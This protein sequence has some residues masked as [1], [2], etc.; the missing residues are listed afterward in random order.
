MHDFK[1][2]DKVVMPV[3]HPESEH[4]SS[5]IEEI[6]GLPCEVDKVERDNYRGTLTVLVKPISLG[7]HYVWVS[8]LWIER[9]KEESKFKVGDKIVCEREPTEDEQKAST[10]QCCGYIPEYMKP[11]IGVV[12]EISKILDDGLR[13][14]I[15]FPNAEVRETT[16]FLSWLK[17]APVVAQQ[18]TP[19]TQ[20]EAKPVNQPAGKH[21]FKVG[22]IVTACDN[23]GLYNADVRK[24]LA[25]GRTGTVVG[26]YPAAGV[27]ADDTIS[28]MMGDPKGSN[29]TFGVYAKRLKLVE[30][31]RPT[32]LAPVG[33]QVPIESKEP[34]A[35]PKQMPPL[36]VGF[37]GPALVNMPLPIVHKEVSFGARELEDAAKAYVPLVD[38]EENHATFHPGSR[39]NPPSDTEVNKAI[40]DY[41]TGL[42]RYLSLS[43]MT[44]VPVSQVKGV[45]MIRRLMFLAV[46]VWAL[47][48]VYNY[49]SQLSTIT[50][51]EKRPA[52]SI[53]KA[54][55]GLV[56]AT[57]PL[58]EGTFSG[59]KNVGVNLPHIDFDLT[60]P[61]NWLRGEILLAYLTIVPT[62]RR[63]WTKERITAYNLARREGIE[64][65]EKA[66]AAYPPNT[67]RPL[68]KT[69]RPPLWV[70]VSATVVGAPVTMPLYWSYDRV[71]Y[72]KV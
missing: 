27:V 48:T 29:C 9:V 3:A 34:V 49:D 44:N 67:Q 52:T 1:V 61:W 32:T 56:A 72:G 62:L 7:K 8:D 64:H 59:F 24:H 12:G 16:W 63:F 33:K 6:V 35:Q 18:P 69:V 14:H 58:Q 37:N 30:P 19:P 70:T 65:N 51:K 50:A 21:K 15:K 22:D 23:A 54:G 47:G 36:V 53:E 17:H 2:G 39:N 4:W 20:Q 5:W 38:K 42:Q 66:S 57:W 41:H 31:V 40:E 68:L 55:A 25:N 45:P 11:G 10:G 46:S 43:G 26:V 28:V 13:C 60:N 71:T